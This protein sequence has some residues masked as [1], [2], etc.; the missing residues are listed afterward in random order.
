MVEEL[1]DQPLFICYFKSF[2]Y[3]S[4]QLSKPLF[5]IIVIAN[6]YCLQIDFKH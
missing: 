1:G 5:I 2:L 6:F 4:A 3:F